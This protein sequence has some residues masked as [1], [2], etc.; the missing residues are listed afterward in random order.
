MRSLN[1]VEL[2]GNVGS[3]PRYS[4]GGQVKVLNFRLATDE[5]RKDSQGNWVES[6]EWHSIVF[7]G[8]PA[9]QLSKVLRSGS[10]VYVSGRIRS[11]DWV[12]KDGAK[13]RVYEI[14]G[15]DYIL[16]DAK[17]KKEPVGSDS[18]DD[19]DIPF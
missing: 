8:A 3:E 11:R 12:K 6:V 10:K 2:I 9:E 13:E 4:D 5:G 14:M 1:R 17:V 16:L 7:F 15:N 19:L 18:G